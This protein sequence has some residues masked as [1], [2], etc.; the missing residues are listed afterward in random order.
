MRF[1]NSMRTLLAAACVLGDTSAATAQALDAG[2]ATFVARCAGCHGSDGNGG[3][4]GPAISARVPTRS[5]QDLTTL[6]R[7]GVPAA[8]MPAFAM[9]SAPEATDLIRFLRTLRPRAGSAPQRASLTLTDGKTV[10]GVV[11]NQSLADLQLLGD[12]RKLHLLRKTGARYRRVTSQ[13]DWLTYNGTTP[14]AA[15]ARS[16]RSPRATWRGWR[17]GGCSAFPARR[18]CRSHPSWPR[19]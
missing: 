7:E 6:L 19:A 3:E 18:G 10:D 15:T 12:D 2:R 5:D 14:A 11:L 13:A 8:G 17:P 9:L 16:S 4:L 1:T